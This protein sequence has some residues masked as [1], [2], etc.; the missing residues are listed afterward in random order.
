VNVQHQRV[1]GRALATVLLVATTVACTSNLRLIGRSSN[2]CS[3]EYA[4]LDG[5]WVLA[6]GE[7]TVR[8]VHRE[9][10]DETLT[11]RYGAPQTDAART[12]DF[13]DGDSED[14]FA[15]ADVELDARLVPKFWY[16][17]V[18]D[19]IPSRR[20]EVDVGPHT[21]DVRRVVIFG[22]TR[23]NLG[24][25]RKV[26]QVIQSREPQLYAH[27]G[28]MVTRGRRID[29]WNRFMQ[30]QE[31]MMS[32]TPFIPVRGNHDLGSDAYERMF[33]QQY[34]RKE[35]QRY[36][37]VQYD[38]AWYIVLETNDH[39]GTDDPQYAFLRDTLAAAKAAQVP[40]L[41]ILSHHPAYSNGKHGDT[42]WY[43][44]LLT[45]LTRKYRPTAV[46]AGHD[47]NYERFKP[48]DGTVFITAGGGGAVLKNVHPD[49]HTAA[50]SANYSF[51]ELD[52]ADGVIEA[53]AFNAL[54]TEID[55]FTLAPR[56]F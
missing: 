36:Y 50:F 37:T 10:E 32:R 22:D 38:R 12:L 35:P 44:D 20:Y 6:R 23:P 56:T 28:D 53:R 19:G 48:R 46:F 41:F 39:F 15:Y 25:A 24:P 54:G 2:P 3:L 42:K 55:R 49:E 51:L 18:A 14:C 43:R 26:M 45:P 8:V 17:V 47:H 40:Y 5:P 21:D 27:T 13:S 34:K 16:R 29:L 33:L 11:L 1:V 4:G 52:I 7:R 31:P 9:V 30:V